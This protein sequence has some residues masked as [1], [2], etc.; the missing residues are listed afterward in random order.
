MEKVKC[1]KRTQ[2]KIKRKLKKTSQNEPTNSQQAT[3][4]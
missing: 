4:H 2:K 1:L 3:F